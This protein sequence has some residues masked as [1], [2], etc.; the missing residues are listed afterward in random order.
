[1]MLFFPPNFIFGVMF[2][3]NRL[4]W[5]QRPEAP[6]VHR[7]ADYV[8]YPY[9][10]T[11]LESYKKYS[12]E[13]VEGE[14]KESLAEAE[15][16]DHEVATPGR[17][18]H[19]RMEAI[20]HL[21]PTG[22]PDSTPGD[23][24]AP[25]VLDTVPDRVIESIQINGRELHPGEV[26]ET[27]SKLVLPGSLE[28]C[29]V[30]VVSW[31]IPSRNTS[32]QGSYVS[33]SVNN[34]PVA[35]TQMETLG[36]RVD[37]PCMDRP[38]VAPLHWKHTVEASLEDFPNMVGQGT[39]IDNPDWLSEP[40]EGMHRTTWELNVP[41]PTYLQAD[42]IGK[43]KEVEVV[44]VSPYTDKQ[45]RITAHV[46]PGLEDR[47][48]YLLEGYRLAMGWDADSEG[49]GLE[50][51][52]EVFHL[53]VVDKFNMGAME[54]TMLN[55]SNSAR[56]LG[57]PRVA[58][59]SEILGIY[60]VAGHEY[61]HTYTGN[62][63]R[64][65]TW[66]QIPYKEG[67]TRLRDQ[68]FME[69]IV[70]P[71][72][73]LQGVKSYRE[74]QFAKD[75]GHNAQPLILR[76]YCGDPMNDMY[77][78]DAY[79]KGAEV[80]RMLKSFVGD[81]AFY[82]GYRVFME[83]FAGKAVT[84][85]DF[86]K[87]VAGEAGFDITQFMLWLDQVGTPVC[88]V[89]TAYDP[90]AKTYSVTVKQSCPKGP[91]APLQFPLR[92][93]LL[94]DEGKDI[95]LSLVGG[96]SGRHSLDRGI[97]NIT[98]AEETFVFDVRSLPDGDSPTPSFMRDFSA[99]VRFQYDYSLDQLEFL[100]V[101]DS[102]VF[103]RYD[104]CERVT[105]RAITHLMQ[106]HKEGQP[107]KVPQELL[108]AY[109]AVFDGFDPEHPELTAE[110]LNFPDLLSLVQDDEVYDFQ[111]AY[112]AKKALKEAVALKF[113]NQFSRWYEDYD[114]RD[115]QGREEESSLAQEGK[116]DVP[117]MHRRQLKNTA[118]SYLVPLG[119]VYSD[120]VWDQFNEPGNMTNERAAF[121]LILAMSPPSHGEKAIRAFYERWKDEPLVINKWFLLQ[122][123][124]DTPDVLDRV[125]DLMQ[126]DAFKWDYPMHIYL[127]LRDGFGGN[128]PHYHDESG[129]GY[130]FMV[131]CLLKVQ[132]L[133]EGVA[134]RTLSK[135]FQDM[136]KMDSTRQALMRTQLE[137]VRDASGVAADMAKKARELLGESDEDGA[138]GDAEDDLVLWAV[139][140]GDEF[141]APRDRGTLFS[142]KG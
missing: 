71:Q 138:E 103:A 76:E 29:T 60:G 7:E 133:N 14:A 91:Q 124:M 25:I 53:G 9:E 113:E 132:T 114:S 43:L 80:Y 44:Y 30:R 55:I 128:L 137:R 57:D 77:A 98:K 73:R 31:T 99:P 106:A 129:A 12:W 140:S 95:P 59:D 74:R 108:N 89:G 134:I 92:M 48:R 13:D 66:H 88:E 8:S 11:L 47:V 32:F 102:D 21:S 120:W 117:S 10:V 39:V 83:K 142:Q 100:M 84:M 49:F 93:G 111:A 70:G 3:E 46:D 68:L 41:T 115:R 110:M 139:P 24:P 109:S 15:K 105:R 78:S 136:A 67:L 79:D 96:D 27:G 135:V 141:W 18:L 35:T 97:L 82:K 22:N 85:E 63:A 33:T 52:F 58:T 81:E 118:L 121:K 122:G 4:I 130:V 50:C 16:I 94:D 112:A 65:R 17:E 104:A 19:M 5:R 69:R 40:E 119:G 123:L 86:L 45:V 2:K 54:N 87:T 72:E 61:A 75:A 42:L 36:R 26:D 23:T 107:L 62:W 56:G 127:L 126:H 64:P 51:P 34:D 131:D 20:Y 6:E 116:I 1:M 37:G 38:D 125:R 90:E 101:H 28:D